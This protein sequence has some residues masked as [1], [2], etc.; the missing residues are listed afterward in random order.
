MHNQTKKIKS[1][2][3]EQQQESHSWVWIN[4]KQKNFCKFFFAKKSHV[5]L[6]LNFVES[7][8]KVILCRK[9][10]F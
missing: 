3:E 9:N 7:K 10:K 2:Q 6:C 8:E 5:L 1:I 4:E